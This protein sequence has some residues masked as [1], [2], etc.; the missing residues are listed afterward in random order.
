MKLSDNF[1]GGAVIDDQTF[2]WTLFDLQLVV[3]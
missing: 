3:R 2:F 1:K